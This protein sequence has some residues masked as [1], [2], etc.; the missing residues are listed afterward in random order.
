[1]KRLLVFVCPSAIFP[2]KDQRGRCLS[3]FWQPLPLRIAK[4]LCCLFVLAV[5]CHCFGWNRKHNGLIN[6]KYFRE[7]K[8]LETDIPSCWWQISFWS[9]LCRWLTS[10]FVHFSA[11][12]PSKQ[13]Q[14]H[15]REELFQT[16]F[17]GEIC[18][19]PSVQLARAYF[20]ESWTLWIF[21]WS[22][23]I[24]PKFSFSGFLFPMVFFL[25]L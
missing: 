1:M 5:S 8:P 7:K 19:V 10:C 14:K 11:A 15:D 13:R 24:G 6:W 21:T 4:T 22:V 16:S 25:V 9:F 18:Q 20:N 2:V 12:F 23:S 3:P 17:R